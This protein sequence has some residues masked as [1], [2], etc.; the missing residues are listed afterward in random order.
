MKNTFIISL[1]LSLLFLAACS[2]PQEK[3]T[4]NEPN[5]STAIASTGPD[6]IIYMTKADYDQLVPVT[7]NVDK[8]DIVAYPAPGDLKYKG[9]VATPTKLANGFLLDNRG[10]N[11]N[12]AFINITYEDYMALSKTPSKE[13][14]M[15]LIVDYDPL[16]EMYNCGKRAL[17]DDA[18]AELN[19]VIESGDLSSFSKIK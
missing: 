2:G 4:N 8:T 7:L 18:A 3:T 14:L 1:M 11:E 6:A 19:A 10:I 5:V 12:V 17:Y 9:K 13:E 15:G 16:V